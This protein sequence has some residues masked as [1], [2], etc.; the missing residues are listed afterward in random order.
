MCVAAWGVAACAQQVKG[1]LA[2]LVELP[3]GGSVYLPVYPPA[4]IADRPADPRA[5]V[6]ARAQC[7]CARVSLHWSTCACGDGVLT[8]AQHFDI[9]LG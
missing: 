9:C 2:A 3:M 8:D 7:A 4:R 1:L 5:L 6:R